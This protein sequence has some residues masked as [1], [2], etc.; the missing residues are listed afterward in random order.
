MLAFE[1]W[2]WLKFHIQNIFLKRCKRRGKISIL[3]IYILEISN[4]LKK[5]IESFFMIQYFSWEKPLKLGE[6]YWYIAIKEWVDQ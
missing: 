6:E 5:N 1:I 2:R 3:F 4:I